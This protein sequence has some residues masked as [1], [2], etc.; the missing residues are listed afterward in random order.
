MIYFIDDDVIISRAARNDSVHRRQSIQIIGN[1]EKSQRQT[2][3]G[4][5][6]RQH[7]MESGYM[8]NSKA[9]CAFIGDE[10]AGMVLIGPQKATSDR[11]SPRRRQAQAR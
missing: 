1:G 8:S 10:L 11:R 7:H 2:L 3:R 4:L 5:A 6:K 9:F